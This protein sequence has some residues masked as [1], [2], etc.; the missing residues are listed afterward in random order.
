MKPVQPGQSL[1]LLNAI[2]SPIATRDHG[3]APPGAVVGG[4]VDR[5]VGA[6]VAGAPI[7]GEAAAGGATAVG[8][9]AG[10]PAPVVPGCGPQPTTNNATSSTPKPCCS[11]G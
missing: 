6:L 10:G 5:A 1:G 8:A 4:G 2:E 7:V 9:A 3:A 11:S